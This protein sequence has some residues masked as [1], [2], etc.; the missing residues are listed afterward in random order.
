[1]RGNSFR[2]LR[3]AALRPQPRKPACSLPQYGIRWSS[4]SAERQWSTPLAK[5][6]AKAIETT[7]PISVAAYMRQ[8]LTSPDGGYYTRQTPGHDQF[9][10]K[11]D[12]I[13]SPEISQ[14]FGELVGIWLY[15]EWLAQGK[16]D[17]VQVI[18][19]GPGRGTLLDDVLRTIS[20]FKGFAQSIE[21]IYLVEASP[22]L[23]S[24][25]AKLLSGTEAVLQETDLGWKARSKHIPGCDIHWCEDIRF[26][27]KESSPTPFILAHE[28]FD[29][30]PIHIFRAVPHSHIPASSTTLTPTGP[31]KPK[32]G[33]SS[34]PSPQWHELLVAPV[35]ASS[36]TTT[37]FSTSSTAPPPSAVDD[38]HLTLSKAPTP[39]SLYLPRTSARYEALATTPDATIEISPE[40]L[41]YIAD[42]AVRIGGA[43]PPPSPTPTTPS[44]TLSSPQAQP[45]S[46][47]ALILDYGPATTIPAATLRGIR[48]HH[49]T[50]PF[51]SAGLVDLSAD[52]DFVAL[53]EAALAASPGVE[54]HG[55]VQQADFLESLGIGE[56]VAG[57]VRGKGKSGGKEEEEEMVRRIEGGWKRLVD[58][59]P[60]GMGRIYKAMAVVPHREGVKGVRRPVGFGGDVV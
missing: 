22:H 8:C 32:R 16:S 33:P 53:A 31:L 41:S 11:G 43:N 1:M 48:S 47:C 20:S 23:R 57:L 59:G 24:Q 35:T 12:F 51:A 26:I 30:L 2:L 6:L 18:E 25:Q 56:R 14:V 21:A 15:T 52:V 34:E 44:T 58:R 9:G 17:R 46:G 54:V 38:F 36:T 45:P 50:S 4:S 5:S 7:G 27:P 40:S 19:V 60:A 37:T 13:T 42:F 29:A 39:H 10:A 55:P 49:A 28:F 3:T